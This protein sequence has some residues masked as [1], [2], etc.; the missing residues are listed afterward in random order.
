MKNSKV[1]SASI[2]A[3]LVLITAAAQANESPSSPKEF[4]K[5][6]RQETHRHGAS[7]SQTEPDPTMHQRMIHHVRQCHDTFSIMLVHMAY[8]DQARHKEM[9]AD[10][11]MRQQMMERMQQCQE[12]LASMMMRMGQMGQ[13]DQNERD[14]R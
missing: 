4:R 13:D 11:A 8:M 12:V 7:H 6:E 9:M 2:A 5:A 3:M 1:L 10:P 14:G